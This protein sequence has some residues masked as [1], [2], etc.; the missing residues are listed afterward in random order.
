MK[1]PQNPYVLAKQ[2]VE[3]GKLSLDEGIAHFVERGYR[4][5][6]QTDRS[7]Q[8]VKPKTFSLFACL[9]LFGIF[10]LP[11]YLAKRD[12]IVYLTMK[13]GLLETHTAKG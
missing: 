4:V 9:V 6:S 5:V 8:L 12:D 2:R 1:P 13:D 11:F 10:Y 7:A 3:F